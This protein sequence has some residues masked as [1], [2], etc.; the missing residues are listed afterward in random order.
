MFRKLT[1][2]EVQSRL[3]TFIRLIPDTYVN[4]TTN[5][6]FIDEE[7]GSFIGKPKKVIAGKKSH[8]QRA[9]L[10]KLKKQA[11]SIDEVKSR[12]NEIHGDTVEIVDN[13]YI[14]ATQK[15]LFRHKKY[16]EWWTKPSSVLKGHSHPFFSKTSSKPKGIEEFL[17]K[18]EEI[19]R[20]SGIFIKLDESTYSGMRNPAKFKFSTPDEDKTVWYKPSYVVYKFLTSKKEKIG[21]PN[22]VLSKEEVKRRLPP[23]LILDETTYESAS[24]KAKF[25]DED[26]GEWW[27]KPSGIFLG[28]RHPK[29]PKN[30]HDRSLP[31][32]E[33]KKSCRII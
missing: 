9:R 19:N 10:S 25:I 30:K 16:G 28:Y 14:S 22:A 1:T 20:S 4:L 27:T 32:E 21:I 17:A 24:Q 5:C 7:Y 29:R 11:L 8:P 15:A 26:F 3:P 13:T 6:E 33:L 2:D 23:E 31:L 18:L 12:I